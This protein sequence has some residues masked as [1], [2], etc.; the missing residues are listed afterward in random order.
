MTP[1]ENP[2]DQQ[3]VV[4]S[5]AFDALGFAKRFLHWTPDPK[6]ELV[7]SSNSR[8]VI[9]N[10]AR[11]WGKSTLAAAK[12]VHV[13]ITRPGAVALIVSENLD[14]T[15]WVFQ[16]IDRFLRQLGITQQQRPLP[17]AASQPPPATLSCA[18][19]S[20]ANHR[21]HLQNGSMIIG[22]AAR[23]EAVRSYTADLVFFDEAARIDDDV[24]DALEPALAV[25]NGDLWMAS[26]P[27]GRRGRFFE[28]W[29]YG[30]EGPDLLKVRV[31]ASEN[32]RITPSFVERIRRE[33]GDDYARQ[34]F[35][36]EFVET[37]VNLMSLDDIDKLLR[38]S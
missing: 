32:P 35:D 25:R 28:A 14:Q 18:G 7:L 30:E 20:K 10:C 38:K 19:L 16:K 26:T 1:T 34:E 27:R 9:L 37:G 24:I 21:R 23:E 22:I 6:Q 33:K 11:Q 12:I 36:C 8:R 4:S 3:V 13:T 5:Y 31:P 17:K 2:T 29:S 15:D